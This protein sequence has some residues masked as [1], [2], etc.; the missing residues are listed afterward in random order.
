MTALMLEAILTKKVFFLN[1]IEK[2]M[3]ISPELGFEPQKCVK[4]ARSTN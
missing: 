2:E 1:T 4:G 3:K